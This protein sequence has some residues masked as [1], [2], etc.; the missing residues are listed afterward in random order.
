MLITIHILHR[1][2][3]KLIF[4]PFRN[5]LIHIKNVRSCSHCCM[6]ECMR[7]G[8]SRPLHRDLQWS[9]VLPHCCNFEIP[10]SLVEV[11]WRFLGF[12]RRN[13][14]KYTFLVCL[15]YYSNLKIEAV[16]FSETLVNFYLNTQR[17]ITED[18]AHLHKQPKNTL[19]PQWRHAIIWGLREAMFCKKS[20]RK[21]HHA[22]IK[23]LRDVFSMRSVPRC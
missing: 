6:N 4:I 12:K 10:C 2:K 5:I 15:V 19:R 3:N 14:V 17:R 23:L 21:L 8:P 1:K 13:Q 22:T 9:I 16:R 20:L 11:H 18:S 7:G